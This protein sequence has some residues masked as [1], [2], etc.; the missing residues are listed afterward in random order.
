LPEQFTGFRHYDA[1]KNAKALVYLHDEGI[2]Y[3]REEFAD[4]D[5]YTEFDAPV[6]FLPDK[7]RVGQTVSADRYFTCIYRNGNTARGKFKIKQTVR[8]V[9]DVPVI[10]GT[11]KECLRIENETYWEFGDGQKTRSTGTYY[12]APNVGIVKTSMRIVT[13]D[14]EG[15]ETANRFIETELKSKKLSA[16]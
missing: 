15:K 8:A 14:E 16:K 12:L 10:A 9:E 6:F 11:F 2:F 3:L 5:S 4:D 1:T 7:L 13:V